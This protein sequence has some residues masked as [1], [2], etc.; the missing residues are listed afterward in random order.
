MYSARH[1]SSQLF[2]QPR[3]LSGERQLGWSL[4][5]LFSRSVGGSSIL[6]QHRYTN[7]L[8]A[9]FPYT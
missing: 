6:L 9:I 8:L 1:L 2:H 4:G 5:S 3:M 7:H